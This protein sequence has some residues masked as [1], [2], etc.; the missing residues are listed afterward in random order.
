MSYFDDIKKKIQLLKNKKP[1]TNI[2]ENLSK[3]EMEI[4]KETLSLF[5]K[6]NEKEKVALLS[7]N[8]ID[9]NNTNFVTNSLIAQNH[10]F[11]HKTIKKDTAETTNLLGEKDQILIT[12]KEEFPREKKEEINLNNKQNFE[13]NNNN[14]INTINE[15]FCKSNNSDEMIYKNNII[16]YQALNNLVQN[17]KNKVVKE[18]TSNDVYSIP[19]SKSTNPE[20]SSSTIKREKFSECKMS[21]N[22]GS[23]VKLQEMKKLLDVKA[24]DREKYYLNKTEFQNR[25]N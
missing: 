2:N 21:S 10:S 1:E 15:I 16:N 7:E 3:I 11:L 8:T 6:N 9:N 19:S 4:N 12:N 23:S 20:K 24:T 14:Q 22:S 18:Y 13:V 5:K 25:R 17:S